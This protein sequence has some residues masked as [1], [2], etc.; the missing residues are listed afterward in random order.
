MLLN[1]LQGTALSTAI[2][3]SDWAVMALEAVHL[4]GLALLGG[5]GCITALAALRR[6]G[7]H[8]MSVATLAHG[9]RSLFGAGL[10]LMTVS[11][12]LIVL[13]MPFKYYLNS[14]FR[15]KMLLLVL[16]VVATA[17]LLRMGRGAAP[18]ARQR[19]LAL[20]AAL[21]WLAVGFSGRLIG[22]L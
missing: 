5:A 19:S 1:W 20:L 2:R 13:S 11:G 4:L 18:T 17:G 10:M 22:F 9:L 8:G 15:M 7:L 12:A 6:A 14:A 21:L 16:A 3:R